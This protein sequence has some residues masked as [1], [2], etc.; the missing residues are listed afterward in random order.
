[1]LQ[2]KVVDKEFAIEVDVWRSSQ[3][4]FTQGTKQHVLS[5]GMFRQIIQEVVTPK[6]EL[7]KRLETNLK[8]Q[9]YRQ[10]LQN[11][12]RTEDVDFF[13]YL[14]SVASANRKPANESPTRLPSREAENNSRAK[15]KQKD[16][17][18]LTKEGGLFAK[19]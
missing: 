18:T 9:L 5:C 10:F 8:R 17:L 19:P 6:K 2:A 3:S 15:T 7:Q 14:Q 11:F 12:K 1:M 13:D 4:N 16:A